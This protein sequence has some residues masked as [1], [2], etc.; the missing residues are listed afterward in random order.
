MVKKIKYILPV[1]QD[2]LIV[3]LNT[4]ERKTKIE[5]GIRS[6]S[7]AFARAE[8]KGFDDKWLDV[9]LEWGIQSDC[10]DSSH[11]EHYK[12]EIENFNTSSVQAILEGMEEA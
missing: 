5:T 12:I 6:V 1:R 10:S 9:E 7:G 3:V 4:L 11:T 8:L 2:K